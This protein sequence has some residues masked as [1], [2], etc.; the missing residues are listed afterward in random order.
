MRSATQIWFGVSSMDTCGWFEKKSQPCGAHILSAKKTSSS[1]R[2]TFSPCAA[3]D[4]LQPGVD[5]LSTNH[6]Q[7]DLLATRGERTGEEH[8]DFVI[9]EATRS[10]EV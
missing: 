2:T 10:L 8:A 7:G 9:T 3:S 1:V 6:V 4:P 5:E